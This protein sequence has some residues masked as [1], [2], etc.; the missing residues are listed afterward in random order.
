MIHIFIIRHKEE[1]LYYDMLDE[2]R[3]VQ[4]NLP[5]GRGFFVFM[6]DEI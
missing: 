1:H 2:P 4:I 5:A 6:P 3:P